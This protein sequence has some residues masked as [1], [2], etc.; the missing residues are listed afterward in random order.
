[1][2]LLE[3][4]KGAHRR[5]QNVI[6]LANKKLRNK[7][8]FPCFVMYQESDGFVLVDEEDGNNAPLSSCLTVIEQKGFLSLEDY[9]DI[10][11]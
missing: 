4:L 2:E 10:R 8:G 6:A 3:K 7:V 11:I 5:Y 9:M 1:M